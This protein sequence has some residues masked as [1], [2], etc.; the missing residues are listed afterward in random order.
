MPARMKTRITGSTASAM[1]KAIVGQ[2]ARH[3][4][5]KLSDTERGLI[6]RAV[7]GLGHARQRRQHRPMSR[8]PARAWRTRRART[9]RPRSRPSCRGGSY[10]G[11]FEGKASFA[12]EA[13]SPCSR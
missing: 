8:A 4:M 3:S 2:M 6:D 12:L 11:F 5:R 7:N 13:I 10:G 1:I 9:W